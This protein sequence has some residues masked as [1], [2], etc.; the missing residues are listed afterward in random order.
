M[1]E[2]AHPQFFVVR[3]LRV[4]SASELWGEDVTVTVRV[5]ASRYPDWA[6][7][8]HLWGAPHS[9]LD[10]RANA[11]L[12][13]LEAAVLRDVH[14]LTVPATAE[15][16][17]LGEDTIKKYQRVGREIWRALGVPPWLYG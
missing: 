12:N 8:S 16:M 6:V 14:G 4:A 13:R 1:P 5:T 9:E 11:L 3:G 10:V 15:R 17:R 2:S 7:I